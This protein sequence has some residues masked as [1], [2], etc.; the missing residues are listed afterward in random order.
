MG[1][2]VLE[3]FP[4]IAEISFSLPNIHYLPVDLARLGLENGNQIFLPTDEPHG[5]IE[6]RLRR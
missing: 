2:A 5:L 3:K 6:A 4:S 1:E